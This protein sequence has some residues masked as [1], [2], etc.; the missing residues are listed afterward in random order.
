LNDPARLLTP[1]G[2]V[3]FSRLILVTRNMNA[4]SGD[5]GSALL[6]M[7]TNE[8]IGSLV[9]IEAGWVLFSPS[10]RYWPPMGNWRMIDDEYPY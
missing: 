8:V 6:T 7:G 10:Y 1:V 9:G 2:I 3:N 4:V 5:S